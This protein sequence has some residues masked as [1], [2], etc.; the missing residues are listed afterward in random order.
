MIDLGDEAI[1]RGTGRL[2]L[3]DERMESKRASVDGVCLTS[4]RREPE[5]RA[6]I[7]HVQENSGTCLTPKFSRKRVK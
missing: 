5:L 4:V 2:V 3:L 7:L 6:S 1:Q